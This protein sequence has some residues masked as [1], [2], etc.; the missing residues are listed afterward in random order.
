MCH[1]RQEAGRQYLF[2]QTKSELGHNPKCSSRAHWVCFAPDSGP[3]AHRTELPGWAD[4]VAKVRCDRL[5]PM[6]LS[7]SR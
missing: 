7:S 6:I 4:F 3:I 2:T 1:S 5:R